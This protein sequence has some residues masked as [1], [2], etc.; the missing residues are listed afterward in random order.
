MT[1]SAARLGTIGTESNGGA[2]PTSRTTIMTDG[3]SRSTAD[4]RP[5]RGSSSAPPGGSFFEV[6]GERGIFLEISGERGSAGPAEGGSGAMSGVKVMWPSDGYIGYQTII[7]C[8]KISDIERYSCSIKYRISND[9]R[10][11]YDIG[12]RTI[13]DF[14]MIS[15]SVNE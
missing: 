5:L 12:Y 11:R 3:G 9:S 14:D 15:I 1:P 10:F 2:D 6:S 7:E 8:G 13:I 4:L